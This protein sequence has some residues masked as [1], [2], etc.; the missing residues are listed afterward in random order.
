MIKTFLRKTYYTDKISPLFA[1]DVCNLGRHF[2]IY[3]PR[4]SVHRL[5][6]FTMVRKY[7]PLI[8]VTWQVPTHFPLYSNEQLRYELQVV[9]RPSSGFFV[10]IWY[11]SHLY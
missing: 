5:Q 1:D 9:L 10:C 8:S 7:L 2:A 4:L 11:A 3:I 6:L